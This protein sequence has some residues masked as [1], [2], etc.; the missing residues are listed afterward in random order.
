[1]TERSFEFDAPERVI[2]G[3]IG[4]PGQRVFVIQA[5]SSHEVRTIKLEKQQVAALCEYLD[6]ILADLPPVTEPIGGVAELEVP[7]EIAWT[8]GNM[9]IAYE[10]DS[11][12]IVIVAEEYPDEPSPGSDAANATAQIHMTRAQAARF[13]EIGRLLVATGRPLCPLCGQPIDP[14]GHSC[15]RTNGHGRSHS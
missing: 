14:S 4:E 5:N 10:S 13:V 6:G 11:D 9:G 1:M 8:V 7:I 3:A 12:T 2:P 15:P